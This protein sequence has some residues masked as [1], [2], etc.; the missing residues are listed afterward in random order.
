M[1]AANLPVPTPL[2]VLCA[3]QRPCEALHSPCLKQSDDRKSSRS[4][5]SHRLQ[6]APEFDP[7]AATERRQVATQSGP[8]HQASHWGVSAA[9]ECAGRGQ[10]AIAKLP[11][12]ALSS[13]YDRAAI[14]LPP[15]GSAA[16]RQ[17]VHY[18]SQWSS[19]SQTQHDVLVKPRSWPNQAESRTAAPRPVENRRRPSASCLP[20]AIR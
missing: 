11:A 14:E 5:R 9:G 6:H 3:P 1:R 19:G 8:R 20:S 15:A 4:R 12:P 10:S 16:N 18:F 17:S 2:S 13:G 7:C